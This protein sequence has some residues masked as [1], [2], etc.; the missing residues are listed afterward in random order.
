MV[1]VSVA[2]IT[3][4]ANTI[5]YTYAD[6]HTEEITDD[7]VPSNTEDLYQNNHNKT[8]KIT[9]Y[10]WVQDGSNFKEESSTVTEECSYVSQVTKEANCQEEGLIT[11]TCECGDSYTEAVDIEPDKHS[12][13]V[14]TVK[15]ADCTSRGTIIY[16]CTVPGCTHTEEAGS[17][18]EPDPLGHEWKKD[19][20]VEP[21]CTEQ[22][23]TWY[24]CERC[25]AKEKK[26]YVSPACKFDNGVVTVPPT[27]TT[28]GIMTYTCTVCHKQY[29]ETIKA[30][31]VPWY[32]DNGAR[33]YETVGV[34][35]KNT[36]TKIVSNGDRKTHTI[37]SY[38]WGDNRK[39][40]CS[41]TTAS[42]SYS[43]TIT[44]KPTC[45]T[46]GLTTHTCAVCKDTY[47]EDA[48]GATNEH[49]YIEI[50]TDY[51]TCTEDGELTYICETC[52]DKKT[53]KI[54]KLG[55]KYIET[56]VEPTCTTDG[57]T[58]HKCD[59]CGDE[60]KDEF[61][62]AKGHDWDN[63]VIVKE[64]TE[65]EDGEIE[66]TCN[67]CGAKEND[68]IPRNGVTWTFI[69]GRKII[70]A[71][72]AETP[73][74]TPTSY[75]HNDSGATHTKTTYKWVADGD[76]FVE[77]IADAT[78]ENC[79]FSTEKIVKKATCVDGQ[80]VCTCVCKNTI[81]EIIPKTDEHQYTKK[82]Y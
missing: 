46:N 24:V 82:D 59:R 42:C 77:V 62:S 81:T 79:D 15:P 29:T 28:T 53:E 25:D 44:S 20:V 71:Q 19:E 45:T 67:A 73:I 74:N 47:T 38:K 37:S 30:N 13:I 17:S 16:K 35:P 61:V 63:G 48:P 12:L 65:T 60:Y 43:S 66:Y 64:A 78:T 27:S 32:Y 36:E 11:Y 56:E 18:A 76:N 23:Y 69:S 33:I 10:H 21:T 58:L 52:G 5:V 51:P 54:N 40:I 50:I 49:K 57:Y 9:T 55:H 72:N 3:A 39:E 75:K 31:S 41:T 2:P 4:F 14:D 80:K 68:V 26:D 7:I 22:G 70:T 8:H 34:T 6:G 1:V